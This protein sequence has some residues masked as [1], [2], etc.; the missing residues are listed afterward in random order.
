MSPSLPG[1]LV[2]KPA[3]RRLAT[4]LG[5]LPQEPVAEAGPSLLHPKELQISYLTPRAGFMLGSVT[6]QA[7][8]NP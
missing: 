2:C 3:P 5:G 1:Q 4:L 8:G 7:G 6:R